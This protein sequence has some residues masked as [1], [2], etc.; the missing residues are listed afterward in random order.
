VTWHDIK[1]IAISALVSNLIW[2]AVSFLND[3][4][5][6]LQTGG[7]LKRALLR[8]IHA[9]VALIRRCVVAGELSI[10]ELYI[11]LERMSPDPD[12]LQIERFGKESAECVSRYFSE[13]NSLFTT[14][15]GACMGLD[16][17]E[18]AE[19][20]FQMAAL[21]ISVLKGDKHHLSHDLDKDSTDKYRQYGDQ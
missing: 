10:R 4:L 3:R 11:A 8:Q 2:F 7:E 20:Y 16:L 19:S 6:A 14:L 13:R 1:I 21:T 12:E 17:E 9:E 5:K 18:M 15:D